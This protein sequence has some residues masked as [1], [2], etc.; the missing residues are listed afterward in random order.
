[1]TD[2]VDVSIIIPSYNSE[3]FL[4]RSVLSCLAQTGVEV[5]IIVVDDEGTDFT[6]DI[7]EMIQ[8]QNLKAPIKTIFRGGGLGQST[9]RNDGM[10][11]ARGR[12]VAFL[13]SDDAFCTPRVLAQ[14]VA[15]ADGNQLDMSVAHFYNVSPAMVRGQTR[16]IDLPVGDVYTLAAAPE[17]VNVV[18]C[19]QILYRRAFLEANGVIFSPKLKQ[20][21]DRLFVVEAL[22]KAQRIGISKLFTVDHFNEENSS[23]KQINAGQLQQYVQHLSE[24]NTA[25][26]AARSKAHSSV[27]FERANAIIYLRQMDEYWSKICRRLAMFERHQSLVDRYFHEMQSMIQDL[28]LLYTDQTL[29]IGKQDGFL[30]EGRMDLLRLALKHGNR[31]LLL[32]ILASGKP[33]LSD[34]AALRAVDDTADEIITRIMSFRRKGPIRPQPKP[35]RQLHELVKRVILH[36]GMP[37]TGSS[38]LQHVL[39]RNRFKLLEQGIH[40]PIFGTN[41][42][43]G[44][45]R[46]RT[47]GHAV[48]VQNILAKEGQPMDALAAEV[49]EMSEIAGCPIDTLILSAENIVSPRFWQN[50][51]SFAMIAAFF[52]GIPLEVVCVLRHPVKWVQSLYVE[53]CGNPWNGFTSSFDKFVEQLDGLG[54]LDFDAIS[55]TLRAP[56]HV[57]KLH[58]GCFET[59]RFAGGIEPWFFDLAGVASDGFAP[60]LDG[61]NN[62]S[63]TSAQASLMRTLKRTTGMDRETLTHLFKILDKDDHLRA[64]RSPTRQ[65]VAGIS[66]FCQSHATQIAAYETANGQDSFQVPAPTA[67]DFETTLDDYLEQHVEARQTADATTVVSKF[68]KRLDKVYA[69]SNVNRII[70]IQREGRGQCV[71]V[72]PQGGESIG[73]ALLIAPTEKL[74]VSMFAWEGE[75]LTLVDSAWLAELWQGGVREIEIEVAT[76]QRIGRRPFR[77]VQLLQDGSFWLVPVAHVDTLATDGLAKHWQ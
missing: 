68:L 31:D 46:E 69:A 63:Q 66:R 17:L 8:Q 12:Y 15:E 58:L 30:R 16:A 53:M 24:L 13:D 33:T 72:R 7:L 4:K 39:E 25:I 74:E 3:H 44:L 62:L 77:I 32:A 9:A 1:M 57:S 28:P 73:P 6:R 19:W 71:Q 43:P 40:Y 27:A 49:R 76:S 48:L 22:L 35:A 36:T 65:M 29:D 41:R 64:D 51:D 14:W 42:E 18:S 60:I 70:T 11:I 56:E 50:G 52:H 54:L 37:K 59:I 23:F 38:S 47:P 61:L 21:E 67:F 55:N 2:T 26:S 5:E 45:R 75:S 34:L 10:K 20:R